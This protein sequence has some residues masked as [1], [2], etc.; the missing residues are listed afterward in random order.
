MTIGALIKSL[1][2]Y[3]ENLEVWL[4]HQPSYPSEFSICH[5][6]RSVLRAVPA[7]GPAEA[8]VKPDFVLLIVREML[9]GD[10]VEEMVARAWRDRD[11]ME[12]D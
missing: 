11:G 6:T 4:A 3:D 9:E 8:D 5:V 1:S 12:E 10:V 2:K 7:R